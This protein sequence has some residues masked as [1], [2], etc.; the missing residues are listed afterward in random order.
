MRPWRRA[1]AWLAFLAPL[2][3]LTYGAANFLAA[4]RDHVPSFVFDW[5][6]HVPFLAWTIFPYWSINVFYGLSLFLCRNEFELGR[7]ARRLL[8]AQI[9]AVACFILWPLRM[10]FHRP[11]TDG[12]AG[13]MFDALTSFDKPF[14]QA[15][16]LHIALVIILWDV[17][18]RWLP[19]KSHV[20]LH[21]WSVLIG[22]S[23]LTTYQHHFIDIPTGA[24]LG[25]I[26]LWWWPIESATPKP[27]TAW[28]GD[29]GRWRLAAMY[30]AGAVV[31]FVTVWWL[32]KFLWVL[33]WPAAALMLVAAN[34]A[35]LDGTGFQ[36]DASGQSSI[37]IRWLL[38][39]YHLGAWINSRI[40]TWNQVGAVEITDGVSLG[41][42]P[43]SATRNRF[44]HLIDLAPEMPSGRPFRPTTALPFLDLIA[45]TPPQLQDAARAIEAARMTGARVLVC[46]ALGYSRSASALAAWLLST[47]RAATP[48][49]AID[50]IR[51]V[52]PTIV[53][54]PAQRAALERI[55]P[56]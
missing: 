18:R 43:D 27:T 21:G 10:T 9:I 56:P 17:Y 36:K 3:Y 29:S 52:R 39:P 6:Q 35:L 55:Q 47:R 20:I 13:F 46:C 40:W 19:A 41:R 16:S 33:A 32:P 31:L 49:A 24:I 38:A 14:N 7:H 25:L 23:V 28:T 42:W 51:S 50:F 53:I 34:Y 8:T 26:C 37:A 1:A 12:A 5:E 22:V 2:F 44:D 48:D 15:P 54:G 45:P 11:Q 30:A 4:R